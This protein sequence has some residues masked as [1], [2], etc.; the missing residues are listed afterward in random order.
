MPGLPFH[1]A[2]KSRKRYNTR[3]GNL[4]ILN[5]T[6]NAASVDTE[7]PYWK[8]FPKYT[9]MYSTHTHIYT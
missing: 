6:I 9:S 3:K 5:N 7:N 4:P 8:L 2:G 1:I